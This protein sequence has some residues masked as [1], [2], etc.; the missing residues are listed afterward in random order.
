MVRG[1]EEGRYLPG[2]QRKTDLVCQGTGDSGTTVSS[3]C[4][5]YS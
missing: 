5:G 1:R 4:N 3:I 2:S